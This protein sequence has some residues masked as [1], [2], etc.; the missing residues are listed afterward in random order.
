MSR[1]LQVTFEG[2]QLWTRNGAPLMV[3]LITFFLSVD[4]VLG[5]SYMLD[6]G[7][8]NVVNF[9]KGFGIGVIADV[10]IL[11]GPCLGE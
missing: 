6:T 10:M 2:F 9:F 11:I 3:L 5:V 8:Y 1:C 7:V 4:M